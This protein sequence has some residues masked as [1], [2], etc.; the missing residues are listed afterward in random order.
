M[1]VGI[2]GFGSIGTEVARA[3]IKGVEDFTLFGVS[4]RSHENAIKRISSLKHDIKIYD[5]DTL[6]ENSDVII[7]CAPKEAFRQIAS[8]CINK[9]KILI[10]VSG[11]GILDNL[12]LEALAKK[13]KT[14]ITKR[15]I[16]CTLRN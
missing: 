12:D 1:K 2:V 16:Y 14:Q 13:N 15:T 10:T 11:S 6:V 8:K 9:R 7:D 5:L 4:S 3:I